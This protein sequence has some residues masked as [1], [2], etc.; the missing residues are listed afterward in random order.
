MIRENGRKTMIGQSV[1][2][3]IYWGVL[4]S[5]LLAVAFATGCSSPNATPTLAQLTTVS[6]MAPFSQTQVFSTP[7]ASGFNAVVT[8]STTPGIVG[9]PVVGTTVTF[10]AQASPGGASGTFP[11]GTSSETQTTN[12]SGVATS[13]ALISNGIT[14][15]YTVIASAAG[16]TTS[17]AIFTVTNT[18][19]PTTFTVTGGDAQ[20][21]T[22]STAFGTALSATVMGVDAAGATV[23]VVGAVVTFTA[24]ATGA[25]GTFGDSLSNVTTAVTN[26]SGVATAATFT[27]NATTGSY[28]VVAKVPVV[29][30]SDPT[31][32][33][34]LTTDFTL[35]N[36]AAAGDRSPI[37]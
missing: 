36:T 10:T 5:T 21:A 15:T 28:T 7:F 17:T 20:S 35:T 11:N 1:I 22:V 3:K 31:N 30:S 24:P 32:D 26:S 8:T 9:T 33:T 6:T 25:S 23:P 37:K 12:S 2:G 29:Q 19:N 4:A 13:D 27:A 18:A 14:G 16:T 34:W